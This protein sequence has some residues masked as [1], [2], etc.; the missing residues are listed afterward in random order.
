M[1]I[2]C[3]VRPFGVV[4]EGCGASF[5]ERQSL[6]GAF[7]IFARVFECCGVRPGSHLMMADIAIAIKKTKNLNELARA[8]QPCFSDY[9]G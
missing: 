2:H 7:E 6:R 3:A 9:R 4:P 5:L 8:T 1:H